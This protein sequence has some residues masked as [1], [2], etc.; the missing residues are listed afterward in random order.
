MVVTRSDL[1]NQPVYGP[2]AV[3]ARFSRWQA[4]VGGSDGLHVGFSRNPPLLS[5]IASKLLF[6]ARTRMSKDGLNL[7]EGISEFFIFY[8][9]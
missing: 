3:P 7:A 8:T 9:P 1:Q 2:I 5:R 6:Q 4:G